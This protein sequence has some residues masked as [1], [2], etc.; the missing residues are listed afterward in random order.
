MKKPIIFGIFCALLGMST[1]GLSQSFTGSNLTVAP[2]NLLGVMSPSVAVTDNALAGVR[3]PAG[4]AIRDGMDLFLVFPYDYRD[5][6]DDVGLYLR[7]GSLGFAS[8]WVRRGTLDYERYMLGSGFRFAPGIYFGLNYSWYRGYNHKGSW[9]VGLTG[10]PCRY[11][12]LAAVIDDSNN[13]LVNGTVQHARYTLGVAVR[14]MTDRLTLAADAGFFKTP[15]MGYGDRTEWNFRV[16]AEPIRGIH[17]SANYRPRTKFWDQSFG[18][19]I[20]LSMGYGRVGG[21]SGFDEDGKV[22]D[23]ADYVQFSSGFQRSIAEPSHRY[24]MMEFKGDYPEERPPFRLFAARTPTFAEMLKRIRMMEEDPTVEGIVLTIEDTDLSFAHAQ[25]LRDALESFRETGKSIVCYMESCGNQEYYLASVADV[26]AMTPTG[27]VSVIGLMGRAMFFKD[28]LGKL[29]ITAELYHIGDY[30]TASDMLTRE[31]MSDAHRE[32]LNWILDDL[33]QQYTMTIAE[34]RGWSVEEFRG[35]IDKGPYTAKGAYEAGLVDTLIYRD[36][37]KDLVKEVGGKQANMASGREYFD[38]EEYETEWESPSESKI[39]IVY[40]AGNIVSGK[41]GSDPLMG[42]NMGSETIADALRTARKDHSV[43]AIVFRIDSG[44]GSGLASDVI[45]REVRLCVEGDEAKPFIV[46]MAG[47]AG[48]GGYYIACLADT[49][50]ADPGTITGSIGVISGKFNFSGLYQKLGMNFQRITRGERADMMSGDRGFTEEEWTSIKAMTQEF[51]DTFVGQVAEGRNMTTQQ[52]DDMGRGRVFTGSQAQKI[53]LVDKL[54]GLRLALEI[55]RSS[56]G[57]PENRTVK[58]S[59][60]P[61]TGGF[62]FSNEIEGV[63][64]DYLS[65]EIKVMVADWNQARMYRDAEPLLL[66]PFQ[67]EVQ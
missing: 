56:A 38:R 49:I 17:V 23:G 29:G 33:Y 44:G 14:P 42:K 3:N 32:M 2:P 55:A 54:G 9:G 59:V 40:A 58:Y 45:L 24:I 27:D 46:S 26:I 20:G 6:T 63:I 52:V 11:L 15:T 30:K 36:Q 66:M 7:L 57:I 37:I 25:E 18:A 60:Y 62:R 22:S 16:D 51:Y 61:E 13:P 10:H 34:G 4:L 64:S 31:S 28:T 47:V 8:E 21:Y 53:G 19:G 50:L 12:S 65:P 5:F 41:S 48:S 39:A 1:S 43:K 67:L 35:I